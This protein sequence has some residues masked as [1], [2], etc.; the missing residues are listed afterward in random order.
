MSIKSRTFAFLNATLKKFK[1]RLVRLSYNESKF[2]GEYTIDVRYIEPSF[3]KSRLPQL[4]ENILNESN[5]DLINLKLKY[6]DFNYPV[7][8]HSFW[9]DKTLKSKE[10]DIRFFRGD[11]VFLWQYR[12]VFDN[13][14][15]K[16]ILYTY[17]IINID[18]MRLL[19]KLKEDEL[20]GVYCF[21][22]NGKYKVSRD[23]LDSIS[24]IYFLE[25]YFKMSEKHKLNILDI[26]AGY[27]R[28]A[29]RFTQ[30]FEENIEGYYC[31]DAVAESTYL[32]EFYLK[33]R[34]VEKKARSIPI[35]EIES[36]LKSNKIDIAIN[37]HS[38]SE[39]TLSAIKWWLDLLSMNK[40][41]YL[42]IVPNPGVEN[43][44]L[45]TEQDGNSLDFSL[46]LETSGYK[47]R[48][49]EPKFLDSSL[50]EL[51]HHHPVYYYLFEL[52]DK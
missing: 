43:K 49:L 45:S 36:F 2:D 24:E 38:F 22:V 39:C 33:F 16:Y 50:Q 6:K 41:K 27:G 9:S 10:F 17:Y 19:D 26:G 47:L 7:T 12:S 13:A 51:I 25:K 29:Y 18:S 44:L 31:V 1:L 35:F 42:M 34:G 52:V 8:Q 20:F 23:L 4:F 40:I 48:V 28:L 3:S 15:L 37:I 32:C 5:S 14:Y 46:Y 11:N 21:D 30:T